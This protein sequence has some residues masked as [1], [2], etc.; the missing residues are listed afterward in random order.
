M[1]FE[2]RSGVKSQAVSVA[3]GHIVDQASVPYSNGQK[4]H[5]RARFVPIFQWIERFRVGNFGVLEPR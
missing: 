1:R 3:Q 4:S 5:C 2:N